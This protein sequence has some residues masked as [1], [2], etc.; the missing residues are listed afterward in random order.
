MPSITAIFQN[1]SA[2][3]KQRCVNPTYLPPLDESKRQMLQN[4]KWYKGF[5]V[6]SIMYIAYTRKFSRWHR[7]CIRHQK[8]SW[9]S[10]RASSTHELPHSDYFWLKAQSAKIRDSQVIRK[11]NQYNIK[12]CSQ[13]PC[14]RTWVRFLLLC[15]MIPLH[16]VIRNSMC[17]K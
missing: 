8:L 3:N 10:W 12:L 9:R 6:I 7:P 17:I 5:A 16:G 1:A 15:S 13:R 4:W 11:Y 14:Q 2:V